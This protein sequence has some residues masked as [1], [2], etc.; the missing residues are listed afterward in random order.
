M[1]IPANLNRFI[2]D[3]NQLPRDEQQLCEQWIIDHKDDPRLEYMLKEL[4]DDSIDVK[5]PGNHTQLWKRIDAMT[6][7]PAAPSRP[8]LLR[9]LTA[10]AAACAV[11]GA[12]FIVAQ[13]LTHGEETVTHTLLVAD[14]SIGE[15][16]LPD[17]TKVW[18]N[19]GSSLTYDAQL[20]SNATRDVTL[21]GE[22]YFEVKRDEARPFNVHMNTM[23][24]QVLGTTFDARTSG[25]NLKEED[26]ILESGSVRVNVEGSRTA[27]TLEPGQR[28]CHNTA[29]GHTTLTDVTA[30]Y[31]GNWRNAKIVFDNAPAIELATTLGRRYNLNIDL[32]GKVGAKRRFSMTVGNES[33]NELIPVLNTLLRGELHVNGRDVTFDRP[34]RK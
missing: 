33:F 7:A 13:H 34:K 3:R 19:G 31:Y 22:G 25:G 17:S 32:G 11:F 1:S 18:L 2:E 28:L 27:V 15:F 26:I 9:W 4:W 20:A 12:G 16:M 30:C 5:Q 29:T 23:A 8:S 24:V 21:T 6:Q 14:G 10:A